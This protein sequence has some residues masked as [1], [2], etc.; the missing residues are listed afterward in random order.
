MAGDGFCLLLDLG[1]LEVLEV[2]QGFRLL[3]GD[4]LVVLDVVTILIVIIVAP[5]V[6]IT[7]AILLI[8]TFPD[9]LHPF[10][11]GLLGPTLFRVKILHCLHVIP[12]TDPCILLQEPVIVCLVM[13]ALLLRDR[14]LG[15]VGVEALVVGFGDRV[16]GRGLVAA[17]G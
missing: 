14:L 15:G 10:G 2:G 11:I 1:G 7:T 6:R 12:P 13:L 17:V 16:R 9:L 5:I 8:H 3:P 4:G